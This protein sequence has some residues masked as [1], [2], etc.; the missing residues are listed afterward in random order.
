[1]HGSLVRLGDSVRIDA[2]LISTRDSEPLARLNAAA[3]ENEVGSLADS[4]TWRL[5]AEVWRGEGRPS[6][7]LVSDM[8]SSI[9]ALRAFLEG[10]QAETDARYVLAVSAYQRAID[11][12]STFW[13][14]YWRYASA[15]AWMLQPV[16]QE[17]RDAYWEHRFELPERA[18]AL[19]E[20]QRVSPRS[21]RLE[22]LLRVTTRYPDY[23]PAWYAYGDDIYHL[24]GFFGKPLE[25]AVEAFERL[26]ELNPATVTGLEHLADAF[27]ALGDSARTRWALEKLVENGAREKLYEFYGADLLGFMQMCQLVQ[28]EGFDA[29]AFVDTTDRFVDEIKDLQPQTLGGVL[30]SPFCGQP[31]LNSLVAEKLLTGRV[32]RSQQEAVQGSQVL[33]LAARGA[34][35][36]ALVVLDGYREVE[37]G[38]EDPIGAYRLASLGT[39]FDALD[40]TNDVELRRGAMGAATTPEDTAEVIWLSGVAAISTDDVES[41]RAARDQLR[42]LGARSAVHLT[43][44]L[45]AL[46]IDVDGSRQDAIAELQSLVVSTGDSGMQFR[47][48]SFDPVVRTQLSQWH[49][50]AGNAE[51]AAEPLLWIESAF[52]NGPVYRVT[53]TVASLVYLQRARVEEARGRTERAI[54]FYREFLQR[55]DMPVERHRHLVEEAESALARLAG[56]TE[57]GER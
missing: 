57:V 3:L 22:A 20:A 6:P 49:L 18:R 51:E 8:T 26:V 5:L 42:S 48:P 17:Y 34:W 47:Y 31:R 56:V 13:M 53:Q 35:D 38:N 40:S 28:F 33:S 37:G 16:P 55:Y 9:D 19:M 44:G 2:A 29:M 23:V 24:G 43:R 21:A 14:A 10:A 30:A 46:L 27:L 52:N 4:L 11:A 50:E 1:M 36:S 39:F 41:A 25:D 12:D 54:R 15:L 7:F 32:S 45:D